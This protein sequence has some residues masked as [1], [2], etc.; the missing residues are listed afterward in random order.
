MSIDS[1]AY[2]LTLTLCTVVFPY[3]QPDT[4]YRLYYPLMRYKTI[5]L[6][7]FDKGSN[8]DYTYVIAFAIQ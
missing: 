7:D 1:L 4:Y 5:I 3:T 2:L 6:V 8:I